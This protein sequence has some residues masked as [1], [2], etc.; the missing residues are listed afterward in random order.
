[1]ERT[2]VTAGWREGAVLLCALA[3]LALGGC[4]GGSASASSAGSGGSSPSAPSISG[5]PVAQAAVGKTYSFT[6]T[7]S[8][9]S[10]KT[11][12]FSVRNKPPWAT[13][14]IATG[15]LSGTPTSADVGSY[16]GVVIS[17]SDGRA[18]SALPAFTITVSAS[19]GTAGSA[20]LSW[21]APTTNTDGTALI[22]LAGYTIDY[23]T[24]ATSLTQQVNIPSASTTSYT[25]SNLAA[26]TW[27]FTIV[28]YTTD[29]SESP[30][31]NVVSTT[32]G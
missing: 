15:R 10:G 20:T 19:Q 9:A 27:Y 4:G 7:V 32:I 11:V 18:S 30:Q 26:G 29:G 21:Q 31:S 12:S 14:S 23:G 5:T 1:M 16:S 3:V 25:F 24:S 8:N 6:P 2:R 28:A 13:F 17:V 22:D